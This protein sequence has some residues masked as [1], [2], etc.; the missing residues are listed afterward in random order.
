MNPRRLLG[1]YVLTVAAIGLPVSVLHLVANPDDAAI[2]PVQHVTAAV[3]N[4]FGPWG[5]V[6]VRLVDFPN[7]GL[8]SFSWVLAVGLT[9]AGSSLLMLAKRSE[10][11]KI[12]MLL[13]AFWALFVIL[14][15]GVGLRQIADGLW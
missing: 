8:R 13:A 12:Q 11:G 14:W 15:F 4:L 3:A 5:V 1:I 6:I 7:A 10:A 9:L 2:T